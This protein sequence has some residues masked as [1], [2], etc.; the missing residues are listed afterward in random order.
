MNTKPLKESLPDEHILQVEP[1]PRPSVDAGWRSRPHLYSGR[2]L[3]A[4]AL[5]TEQR[6]RAGRLALRGQMVTPGVVAGLEVRLESRVDGSTG[7][8]IHLFQIGPGL[9][10]THSGENVVIPRPTHI[11]VDKVPVFWLP[12]GQDPPSVDLSILLSGEGEAETHEGLDAAVLVL[13][14]VVSRMEDPTPPD[15]QGQ[16]EPDAYSFEDS[17][18]V[19]GCVPVLFAW[20]RHWDKIERGFQWRNRLAWTIFKQELERQHPKCA[21]W[22]YLGLPI[23]LIGFNPPDSGETSAVPH[24][25][26]RAAVVRAGGAPRTRTSLL[27]KH[28]TPLLWQSRIQQFSE[29]LATFSSQEI[30][31]GA[32]LQSF[33]FLPPVGALP[34]E[35]FNPFTW[36]PRFFPASF[37]VDAAPV[38]LEQLDAVTQV[39]ASLAPLN[40][41]RQ[42]RV[43]VLVPVPEAHFD[44]DLLKGESIDI[45]FDEAINAGLKRLGEWLKRRQILRGKA[46][47]LL[48][49][50][51]GEKSGRFP[52]PDPARIPGETISILEPI[53]PEEDYGTLGS[54]VDA[55]EQAL[56]KW[57]QEDT[58][59][60]SSLLAGAGNVEEVST[61]S[62]EP[63]G[64]ALVTL[65]GTDTLSYVSFRDSWQEWETISGVVDATR[66]ETFRGFRTVWSGDE[67]LI[68]VLVSVPIQ[69]ETP[70]GLSPRELAETPAAP[71]LFNYFI[72]VFRRTDNNEWK[73][74]DSKQV[75]ATRAPLFTA[76]SWAAGH[77]D[78]FV[79]MQT[80]TLPTPTRS[81]AENEVVTSYGIQ[82]FTWV[83]DATDQPAVVELEKSLKRE[84]KDLVALQ[85]KDG[86][87]ELLFLAH[88]HGGTIPKGTFWLH[89]LSG[90]H[91]QNKPELGQIEMD[92][93]TATTGTLLSACLTGANQFDVLISGD[94]GFIHGQYKT[95]DWNFE[96]VPVGTTT[97]DTIKAVSR[98]DGQLHAFLW[99][100]GSANPEAPIPGQLT[101]IRFDGA[102]WHT[103]WTQQLQLK[104]VAQPFSVVLDGTS[105]IDVFLASPQGLLHLKTLP[106]KTREFVEKNGLRA[107]VA[108]TGDQ[109]ERLDD[110]IRSGSAQ[111]QANT[112]NVRQLMISGNTEASRLAASPILGATLVQ[113]PLAARTD[114]ESYFTRFIKKRIATGLTAEEEDFTSDDDAIESLQQAVSLRS[115]LLD[116][117]VTL[118]RELEINV[119]GIVVAGIAIY[120]T[121]PDILEPKVALVTDDEKTL[122]VVQRES[123]ALELL[124]EKHTELE[125]VLKRLEK[126]PDAIQWA[127]KDSGLRW[128]NNDSFSTAV[129]HLE[130]T[131]VL[132]REVERRTRPSANALT[133][134][135]EALASIERSWSALDKRLGTVQGEVVEARQDV[136]VARA[137]RDEEEAR[138]I[139][140]NQRRQ[141]VYKEHVPFLVFQRPRE[142]EITLDAPSRLLD[143]SFVENILPEVFASTAAAPPELLAYVELVHDSPLRW[144]ALSAQLLR[145]LD[146]VEL[147]H[148]T[149]EWARMRAVQ[150]I[151]VQ[152]PVIAGRTSTNFAQGL[153]RLLSAREELVARQRGA[154]VGIE[155]S[156]ITTR[157]W[158]E[159]QQTARAQLSLGDIMDTAHGRSD[160]GRT[161]ATE[162]EHISKVAT[163][164][165]QRFGEV[166]PST[167]LKWAEQMSQYDIPVNLRDLSRLPLWEKIEVTDRREMQMLVDWLFQ[168]VVSTEPEAVALINDLVRVCL[169]L[170]SHAP[171][172]E[173]ISGHVTKPTEA[174]V[175]GTIELAVEPTRVRI[176]MHVLIRSGNQTVQAVV[177]DL[178]SNVVRARVLSAPSGTVSL[179]VTDSVYFSEPARGAGALLPYVG[180]KR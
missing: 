26:D 15:A 75:K 14:P 154:V 27:E 37:L 80:D 32:A 74:T 158:L 44:P 22:E 85:K 96:P 59:P 103:P 57:G 144:F 128:E 155:P 110:L 19:D 31:S 112:Q 93:K 86:R 95:G 73:S 2:A 24:F 70:S 133:S 118:L 126:E 178:A 180:V 64:F 101:Y 53:P 165:Y 138:I 18:W 125:T 146:R 71:A 106:D 157:S 25:A 113:S 23:A 33:A 156:V 35:A 7:K 130:D 17:H 61:E 98:M 56:Q 81:V 164:L 114:I 161:A 29:H 127:L 162:L 10:L 5:A 176:G 34:K 79:A 131:L 99:R 148:R 104:Q 42:E 160:V 76:V 91:E 66:K 46:N 83:K 63:G 78:V 107:L 150:R 89:H 82:K 122:K 171:V 45:A 4:E 1:R 139:A 54:T 97:A 16:V 141:D 41:W 72:R 55:Y 39:S 60:E 115:S 68:V 62:P 140:I 137:L 109:L 48:N 58:G 69:T 43:R 173:L 102:Q 163:G 134:Y 28:G 92:E 152:M 65:K 3:S 90:K 172:N 170:A 143:T 123:I 116:R 30:T 179:K 88:D 47:L 145:G 6:E 119:T 120:S 8:P 9:G 20:P 167:R 67:L 108:Q 169:L 147:I 77:I 11:R 50:L 13:V 136:T 21:P 94:S 52:E 174:K 166:L 36:S 159:L 117:L 49:T 40:T 84:V 87:I 121:S 149:F 12:E 38:P 151:P 132:L 135:K 124:V 105:Q 177:E 175:G 168:R 51:E 153:S 111:V 142:H 129:Q 100:Q